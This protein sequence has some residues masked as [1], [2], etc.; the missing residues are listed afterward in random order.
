MGKIENNPFME[1]LRKQTSLE[2]RL[3]EHFLFE[4]INN[5][6]YASPEDYSVGQ[7]YADD[8]TQNVLK[9]LNQ[10]EEDGSPK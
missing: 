1:E 4:F 6:P 3:K 2:D 10:W 7:L 5:N 9:I 8:K